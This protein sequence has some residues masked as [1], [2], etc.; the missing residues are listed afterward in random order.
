M[1]P[2]LLLKLIETKM[3]GS[4][5]LLFSCTVFPHEFPCSGSAHQSLGSV[6]CSYQYLLDPSGSGSSE[7]SAV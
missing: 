5:L 3:K 7:R 2:K 4:N 1:N 6:H